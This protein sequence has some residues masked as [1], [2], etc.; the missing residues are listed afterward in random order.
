MTN[1]EAAAMLESM[2]NYFLPTS[3]MLEER[4][5]ITALDLAISALSKQ[6]ASSEQVKILADVLADSPLDLPCNLMWRPTGWCKDH[7]KDGQDSPDVECWIRY[8]RVMTESK[9]ESDKMVDQFRDSAKKTD[10]EMNC[11]EWW[12]N[13]IRSRMSRDDVPDTN[14]GKTDFKPDLLEKL[15]RYEP[16]GNPGIIHCKDCKHAKVVFDAIWC[17]KDGGYYYPV[18]HFCGEVERRNNG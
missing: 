12:K 16:G 8:A 14:V 1:E 15:T 11:D 2:K 18:H 3:P 4:R 9:T 6:C 7:C 10:S 5:E 13:Y 17:D